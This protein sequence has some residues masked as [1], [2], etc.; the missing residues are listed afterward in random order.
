MLSLIP[1]LFLSFSPLSLSL[2][3][4]RKLYVLKLLFVILQADPRQLLFTTYKILGASSSPTSLPI[5]LFNWQFLSS[6]HR[7]FFAPYYG[8]MFCYLSWW[9]FVSCH[10]E[11]FF[12]YHEDFSLVVMV[13]FSLLYHADFSFLVMGEFFVT[14]HG[15]LFFSCLAK[16]FTK[17]MEIF[18][19]STVLTVLVMEI[20][21]PVSGSFSL[22]Y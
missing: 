6:Y 4:S 7:E 11:F 19:Y 14:C 10:D 20:S 16:F 18:L 22:Q 5:I 8:G 1:I 2:S 17:P 21:L 3:L 15:E 12:T 13:N 9:F